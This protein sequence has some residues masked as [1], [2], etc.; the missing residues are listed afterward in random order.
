M[1]RWIPGK[2]HDKRQRRGEI[3][4]NSHLVS[5]VTSDATV[6]SIKPNVD[7]MPGQGGRWWKDVGVGDD[8]TRSGK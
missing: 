4:I 5:T 2:N 6:F 3:L 7:Q 8:K 1:L